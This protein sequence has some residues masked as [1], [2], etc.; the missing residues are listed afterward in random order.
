MAGAPQ[1]A[2]IRIDA[3]TSGYEQAMQRITATTGRFGEAF[4]RSMRDA[5]LS[6]RDLDDTLRGLALRFSAL[7]L[8]EAFRP[9]DNLVG[10]LV[11]GLAA[12]LGGQGAGTAFAAGSPSN[13]IFNVQTPDAASFSRSQGQIATMLARVVAR[14]GRGM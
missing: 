5:V 7:A 4:S 3:D 1:T 12:P 2:P 13:V 14:G 9:L 8:N 11:S 6:G 10:S